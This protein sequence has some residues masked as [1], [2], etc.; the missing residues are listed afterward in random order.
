MNVVGRQAERRKRWAKSL[1]AA[2]AI[3]VIGIVTVAYRM[4]KAATSKPAQRAAVL[5][6]GVH[7]ELSGFTFTRS[8]KG[9]RVFT[10]RARRTLSLKKGERA[11]L[12]DVRVEFFGRS[13]TRHDILRTREGEYDGDSGNFSSR[14]SVE[15]EL[16]APPRSLT[17]PPSPPPLAASTSL[18]FFS[19][20]EPVILETSGVVYRNKGALIETQAPVHFTAG[21]ISGTAVGMA[22]AT[23]GGWLQLQRQVEIVLRPLAGSR[24][25]GPIYL[26]ASRLRYDRKTAAGEF[27]GPVKINEAGNHAV[28]GH[29]EL[30]L[31]PRNRVTQAFLAGGVDLSQSLPSGH[32]N[33]RADRMSGWLDPATEQFRA[34]EARGHVHATSFHGWTSARMAADEANLDFAGG[35]PA[36]GEAIGRVEVHFASLAHQA[37][38]RQAPP[39]PSS[40]TSETLTAARL[41]FVWR[42]GGKALQEATTV[43]PGE[44]VI[45]PRQ[46][47]AGQQ[48]ISAGQ[49]QFRFDIHN[50]LKSFFGSAATRLVALPAPGS[51]PNSLP[52]VSTADRL[53]AFLNPASETLQSAD[54]QGHFH[55]Q[56]GD[57]QA[58]AQRAQYDASRETLTLTGDPHAW[59]PATSLR[60][61]QI[62]LDQRTDTVEGLGDVRASYAEPGRGSSLP[63]QVL[64]D[65]VTATRADQTIRF[66]GHVRAW[67]GADIIEAP[68]LEI[69]RRDRRARA[70]PSVVSVYLTSGTPD[71]LDPGATHATGQPE[72][73][74]IQAAHFDY[75]DRS[76]KASYAGHVVMKTQGSVLRANRLEVYF[77]PAKT[78][79]ASEIARAK[80][81]GHVR[82]TQPGRRATG[83]RAVYNA[84]TGEIVM[85]GGPPT[86][87]DA[88]RGLTIG[89][90]LT[91]FIRN[92]SVRV[93]EGRNFT[94]PPRPPVA[95]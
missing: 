90:R 51:P 32:T 55:Y 52:T 1:V 67:H 28:A 18:S 46:R 71:G 58:T 25:P 26:S 15:I 86:L 36:S 79:Q 22:Y 56:R 68:T 20:R 17:S 40:K 39:E 38:A 33:L 95:P 42:P 70:G 30:L 80:V 8:E 4:R 29:A 61:A 19:G 12:Q 44:L 23:R 10:I 9:Q 6:K 74:T 65:R 72:P 34:L 84:R 73:V 5:P 43:G 53:A 69:F 16:N 47:T 21:P 62:R 2:A 76:R 82:V 48:R 37:P 59:D 35:K 11:I 49:L 13:G 88:A 91:F 92:D 24:L 83:D 7:E 64:A 77:S 94:R 3:L 27:W 66:E 93:D 85:T 54:Q 31:D 41:K 63:S 57:Q 75:S 81:E 14:A 89:R 87:Y 60:G 45:S 50:R 78:G